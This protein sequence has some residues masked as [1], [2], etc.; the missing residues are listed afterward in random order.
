VPLT[1]VGER[2]LPIKHVFSSA[3]DVGVDEVDV[4]VNVD[5]ASTPPSLLVVVVGGGGD[6]SSVDGDGGAGVGETICHSRL[7]SSCIALKPTGG[8]SD[9]NGDG[10]DGSGDGDCGS[11]IGGSG[12]GPNESGEMHVKRMSSIG[13]MKSSAALG[14]ASCT[15]IDV[16][17]ILARSSN[18]DSDE[19]GELV[20]S[21]YE[22]G[23]SGVVVVDV[24]AA[25][26]VVVAGATCSS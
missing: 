14:L 9:A 23:D 4:N 12:A 1:G 21:E 10:S 16:H 19:L 17:T 2:L 18:D 11:G 15:R 26:V 8:G 25:A 24:D 22:N 3:T 6:S 5:E 13:G 7:G 20:A